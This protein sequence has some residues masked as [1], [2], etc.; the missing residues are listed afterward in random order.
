MLLFRSPTKSQ[1]DTALTVLRVVLGITFIMHGGQKI[2]VYGFDG[3]AGSFAQMG[4][5][6]AGLMGPF[7]A[8]VEFF[9]GIAIVL[10]LLTRLAA[11]GLAATMVVAILTVHLK[12]GF[13]NPGGI[14]FPLSLLGTAITLAITGAGALSL[15]A[16]LAKR[17]A[18]ERAS[19]QGTP[20][21]AP[22][23]ARRIA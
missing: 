19:E 18:G 22:E 6:A 4:I 7:V 3:V 23:R 10:G 12:A 17:F 5:P 14:E 20:V 15:D 1:I 13:F 2:F 16:L 21:A 8:L 9:G 11:L